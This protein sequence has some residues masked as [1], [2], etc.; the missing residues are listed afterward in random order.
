MSIGAFVAIHTMMQSTINN[1]YN[2]N[3]L[4]MDQMERERRRAAD[5]N[6]N[7]NHNSGMDNIKNYGGSDLDERQLLRDLERYIPFNDKKEIESDI[8][9][10][11]YSKETILKAARKIGVEINEPQLYDSVF[12]YL[13]DTSSYINHNIWYLF[14]VASIKKMDTGCAFKTEYTYGISFM[15]MEAFKD[16]TSKLKQ[17]ILANANLSNINKLKSKRDGY[18]GHCYKCV[19]YILSTICECAKD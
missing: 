19:N 10:N 14:A 15:I 2:N 18:V 17:L 6:N 8:H 11:V 3:M 9:N 1:N 7:R 16:D 12:K 5:M 13:S 4:M